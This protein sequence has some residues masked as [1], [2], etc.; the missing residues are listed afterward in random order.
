MST[1][2]EKIIQTLQKRNL[3]ISI[4]ESC[5]GGLLCER[6]TTPSGASHVFEFG[7]IVYSTQ[8]K[9]KVLKIS[10]VFLKTHGLV[11]QATAKAM[12]QGAQKISQSDI[13][14]SVTGVAGPT[15][16]PTDPPIGTICFALLSKNKEHIKTLFLK[17]SRSHI[18]KLAATKILKALYLFIKQIN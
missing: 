2:E 8:S 15:R 17:G 4:A 9:E 14:V 6:L 5:T 13:S 1:C 18:R 7:F 3:K 11:S 16:H 12:A 10:P